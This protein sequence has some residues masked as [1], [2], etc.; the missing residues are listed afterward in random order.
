MIGR[1]EELKHLESLY[2]GKSFEYLVMYGRRR[3]GKTTLLQEFAKDKDA[4]FYSAQIKND[5]LNLADFSKTVQ[6][7]FDKMFIS[8]FQ[9]WQDAFDYIGRKAVTR[10]VVIID[11][12][13][14]IADSNPSV[15]SVLQHVIDHNW[16]NNGNIFLIL[17]GSSVSFM[18]TEVM[19][20]KSP[21]HDRQT[22]CLEILP[23]D[24]LESSLFFPNY[25]NEEK[26]IA[27]GILGG[28]PRYL[29]AFDDTKTIGRNIAD[30]IIRNGAFLHEEPANLLRAELRETS[31]YNS[32]LS[33]VANGRN[34]VSEIA[35]FIHEDLNK[36]SKYLI[37]L[38]VMRLIE[39]RVPCGE[40][41]GSR[42]GIYVLTDNFFKFW[43][44]YE[45]TN[46]SYYEMLGA[47]KAAEE[48]MDDIPNLMGDA[49]ESI[50]TEY[51]T[52]LAKKGKL[53]FVPYSIGRWWGNNPA[54]RAQDDVDILMLSRNGKQGIFVECKFTSKPMPYDEY[55]DLKTAVS[56]FGN[57][58]EKYMIFISKSG[59]TDSVT[60]AA[61][62]DGATLLTIDN[63]FIA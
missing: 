47:D 45:F 59:F 22:S 3:V 14:F 24:Y 56:A 30:K 58:K 20:S 48:I 23:F 25:T 35:G 18:E 63:L 7:H 46:N 19:G 28:V 41:T 37:T 32:I 8:P 6:L 34:K 15:K 16:K 62:Q 38:Q 60:A 11:E 4:V 29:E 33:A 9:S 12:F 52:R 49:F 61:E 1:S 50:C 5:P 21:L 55:E 13:P 2:S 40:S 17:C 27:Y 57:V 39:K 43:F 44:R 36:V 42:K 54:I 26:L 31:I 10:T 51:L 53:P